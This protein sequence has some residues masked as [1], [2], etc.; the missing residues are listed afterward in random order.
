MDTQQ[1]LSQ[2]HAQRTNLEAGEPSLRR[3]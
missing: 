1:G 2:T 3:G